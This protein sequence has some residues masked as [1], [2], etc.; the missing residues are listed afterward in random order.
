LATCSLGIRID[1]RAL[2]Q[3]SLRQTPFEQVNP[4][5]SPFRQLCFMKR[6]ES[7]L[8]GSTIFFTS[9]AIGILTSR[10]E[11][12][13]WNPSPEPDLA[14]Y[15][16]SYGEVSTTPATIDVGNV[17]SRIFTNL[18][19]GRTYSFSVR[20]YNTAGLE[21]NPSL[22]LNYT[23]PSS[24]NPPPL[25]QITSPANGASF[26]APA[27]FAITA[28]ATD[29]GGSI[30]KVDFY[31]GGSLL[32]SDTTSP[33]SFALS[34]LAAGNY[35]FTA[36]AFDNGGASRTSAVVNVTVVNPANQPPTIS[37][38]ANQTLV[39]D[40]TT[41]SVSFT[42]GDP[43]TPINNLVLSATSSNQ[44]LISNSTFVF[45]GSGTNRTLSFRPQPDRSGGAVIN[46]TVSDGQ[47]SASRSFTVT[48]TAVNDPPII[49]DVTNRTVAVNGTTGSIPVAISDKETAA[50]SMALVAQ[51]SNQTLIPQSGLLLG[52]SGTNRTLT[53]TPASNQSGQATVT[54]T[55]SDGT[56]TAFDTFVVTVTAPNQ[57]P[58]VQITGP[59]NNASFTAPATIVINANA[60][61]SG[62]AVA[63]VDFYSGSTLLGSDTVSPYSFTMSNVSAGSIALT[64]RATDNLGLTATSSIVN[65]TVSAPYVL[66]S[67]WLNIPIATQTGTFTAQFDATPSGG[68]MDA[69]IGFSNGGANEI[70]DLATTVRFNS[71]G[72]IDARDAGS[73]RAAS[74]I[75]YT[76]NVKYRF[77]LVVNI[78]NHTYSIFVTPSGGSELV[79]GSNYRFRTSQRNVTQLNNLAGRAASGGTVLLSALTI[80]AGSQVQAL[81]ALAAL[82]EPFEPF[83]LNERFEGPG[84]E[85]PDWFEVGDPD[86][87]FTQPLEGSFSLNTSYGAQ[88]F[89]EFGGVTGINL[90]FELS[91]QELTSSHTLVDL[92]DLEGQPAGFLWFANG[93]IRI[94]HGNTSARF[95]FIPEPGQRYFLWL[96]WAA[97]PPDGGSM[98]LFLSHS[99]IKPAAPAAVISNGTGTAVDR[100]YFGGA[101]PDSPSLLFDNI[102]LGEVPIGDLT[103]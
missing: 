47:A 74:Q 37:T 17:I 44:V 43:N 97:V 85:N 94:S 93:Q 90:A 51:S 36:R 101:A 4:F 56:T 19:G 96:E 35:A 40:S 3:R 78:P 27:A 63:R 2:K 7:N 1:W 5:Y 48:V 61:D 81:S 59:T 54:L 70:R 69:L 76:P 52:G 39:E 67:S 29:T 68:A 15:R 8:L 53:V 60:S 80:T 86:Q 89:R 88:S 49:G 20:A 99:E 14:G 23:K 103:P 58:V 55:V 71:S 100:V 87:A 77:R 92:S 24:S 31:N 57:R 73:H 28:T 84:Y 91:W 50:T 32:G 83:L 10:A 79:V 65:V 75:R 66:N 46:V 45:G 33:Y 13:V 98:Q 102:T 18:I 9:V 42:V 34:G 21:S 25:V 62:G 26:T 64:A 6:R 95:R 12:L 30:T 22:T 38:I 16:V 82:P 41:S 11:T 72:Y